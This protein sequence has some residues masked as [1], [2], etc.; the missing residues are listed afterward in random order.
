MNG[1]YTHAVLK[2]AK[3][4]DFRVQDDFGGSVEKLHGQK[5]GN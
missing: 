3:S 5:R 1:I 2:K 4:G